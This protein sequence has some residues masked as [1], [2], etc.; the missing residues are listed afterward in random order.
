MVRR[1]RRGSAAARLAIVI[2][3]GLA[4]ANPP[5]AAASPP[6]PLSPAQFAFPGWLETPITA[7][8]AGLALADRWLANEPFANPAIVPG[9]RLT[10]S[11][12]LLRVSRQD[13]RAHNRGFDETAGHFDVAGA[14]LTLPSGERLG[15]AL[16]AFQ[17]VLRF[18]DNAYSRGL[19]TPDPANPPALIQSHASARELRAG[20]ALSGGTSRARIGVGIEW[21]RREDSYRT[22]EESGDPANAGTKQLEF[23]G[24]GIGFQ[25]GARLE[26]GDATPRGLRAGIA[27]RVVPAL[28]VE[29]RHDQILLTGST[30]D[31]VRATRA[32]GWEAGATVSWMAR[33][34]Y[35]LLAA[36]GGRS[37]QRWEG[38]DLR[39][40]PAW[41]WKLAWEYRDPEGPWAFRLGLG[42][43]G[44]SE[45]PEPRA[46]AVGLGLG[47]WWEGLAVDVGVAHRT[48][49]RDGEPNSF[50]DRVVFTV[51]VPR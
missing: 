46:L 51:S 43:E 9:L 49:S 27:V 3:A 38:I 42:Q 19:G 21:V 48:V 39:A 45:V 16:Y 40:G 35:R 1:A 41:E 18:E 31:T 4:V 29:G 2:L 7:R 17:P 14:S 26:R 23:S 36:V 30:H 12:A 44:Q 11:P 6:S 33:P 5:R 34:T 10:A 24:D 22:T 20:L 15:I 47:R 32:A 8:S 50:D 13:L 37:A 28:R 25:L